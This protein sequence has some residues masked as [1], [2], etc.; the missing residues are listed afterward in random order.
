MKVKSRIPEFDETLDHMRE[1]QARKNR[2]YAGDDNPFFNFEFTD[3]IIKHFNDSMDKTFVWPIA[4]KL[5]RLVNLLN[6]G[7]KPEHES[8]EDSLED[9]AIYVLL[10]KAH[11]GRR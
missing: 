4:N 10:W 8:I 7:I 9:I 11:I 5:G 1:L 2:D 6:T 3:S